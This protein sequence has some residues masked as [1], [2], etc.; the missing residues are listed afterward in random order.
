M[1]NKEMMN[2]EHE[3]SS[4]YE[5]RK[6]RLLKGLQDMDEIEKKD[7]KY[8]A[9]SRYTRIAII[10]LCGVIL[11]PISIHAAVNMYKFTVSQDGHSASGTI[12]LGTETEEENEEGNEEGTVS[13]ETA[14]KKSEAARYI[15]V[16]FDYIP[17]GIRQFEAGK[18]DDESK[19]D[20]GIS[21]LATRWNGKA[22]DIQNEGIADASTCQAGEYE[23]LLFRRGGVNA[24]FDKMAYI[25]VGDWSLVITIYVGRNITDD[26]LTRIIAS[27]EIKNAEGDDP[28]YW[29]EVSNDNYDDGRRNNTKTDESLLPD[30]YI[31]TDRKEHF[32]ESGCDM[33]IDDVRVYD[34]T[35]GIDPADM[36]NWFI[37]ELKDTFVDEEGY[38]KQVKCRKL[39]IGDENTFSSWGEVETSS[40]RMVAV[41]IS[42]QSVAEMFGDQ[43]IPTID[44]NALLG[45]KNSDGEFET[46]NNYNYFYQEDR[47]AQDSIDMTQ[48]SPAY[49]TQD[50]TPGVSA[51]GQIQLT[52]D[53]KTHKITVYFLA[54]E[55]EVKDL[56][57]TFYEYTYGCSEYRVIYIGDGS[58][59]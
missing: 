10:L 34:N 51:D 20:R 28:I 12:E 18:Y 5:E 53:K 44:V 39:N 9:I 26:E 19:A 50:G 27:M 16:T 17:D 1:E 43:Y 2:D 52:P 33:S 7:K 47:S 49:V 8:T 15:E 38:F 22:Y 46:I 58:L 14:N 31:L 32:N 54:D 23:Y 57:L 6:Q 4:E 25:P 13:S 35:N 37:R 24:S 59:Q 40:L 21:V 30:K 45:K 48:Y 56:Y 11:L 36:E 55:N 41:D 3:F 29:I 42:Y